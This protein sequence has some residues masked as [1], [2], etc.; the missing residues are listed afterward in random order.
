MTR[1]WQGFMTWF[2]L[3]FSLVPF[4]APAAT[5]PSHRKTTT[6]TRAIRPPDTLERR[7]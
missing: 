6:T 2:L 1:S 4:G 5:P 7:V 3:S